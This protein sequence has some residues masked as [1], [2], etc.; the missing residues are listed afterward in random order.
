MQSARPTQ[1]SNPEQVSCLLG[2]MVHTASTRACTAS[3]LH[4]G[5]C[6]FVFP[7]EMALLMALR[8][9]GIGQE[10]ICSADTDLD[11]FVVFLLTVN[12]S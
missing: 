7:W 4:A 9:L 10:V 6:C 1:S 3:V 11:L 2:R 12:S 8:T 5:G